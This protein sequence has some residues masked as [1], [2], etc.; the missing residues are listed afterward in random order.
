MPTG[1]AVVKVATEKST[2]T[3]YAV[4]IMNL[5]EVG[6]HVNADTESTR[7]DIFKEIDILV[8]V[9]HDN[10]LMLKEY[11]EENGKVWPGREQACTLPWHAEQQ[12]PQCKLGSAASGACIPVCH[13]LRTMGHAVAGAQ[14]A[15]SFRDATPASL[16]AQVYL[17]TELLHGGELLDAVLQR[18][19]YN[20]Q[21]ARVCF[22]QLLKGIDYLHSK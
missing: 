21:D 2:S 19:S 6:Q 20:E 4:K 7:E 5:P 11:F 9:D 22:A 18:G 1:F 15:P 10:V 16:A 14:R 13:T 17:I 12:P 8:G 3:D